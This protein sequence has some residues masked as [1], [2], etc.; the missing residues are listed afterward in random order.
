VAAADSFRERVSAR[1]RDRETERGR[2][3]DLDD[4]DQLSGISDDHAAKANID[5]L[6]ISTGLQELFETSVRDIRT[7]GGRGGLR[8][9]EISDHIDMDGPIKTL[10]DKGW[11]PHVGD[12]HI[13]IVQ[14]R[15]S[16]LTH[17]ELRQ[18]ESLSDTSMSMT[19]KT[20]GSRPEI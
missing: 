16:T 10:G 1:E 6:I 14:Q 17:I 8:S 11:R 2:G 9:S 15:G 5:W 19:V 4:V 13:E 3:R 20:L 18:L 7:G 12:G